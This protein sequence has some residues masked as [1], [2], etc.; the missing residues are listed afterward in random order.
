VSLRNLLIA[1]GLLICSTLIFEKFLQLPQVLWRLRVTDTRSSN[2]SKFSTGELSTKQGFIDSNGDWKIA[3]TFNFAEPFSEGLAAVSQEEAETRRGRDGLTSRHCYIDKTGK[4]LIKTDKWWSGLGKFSGGHARILDDSSASREINTRGQTIRKFDERI[5]LR[6]NSEIG[7]NLI[8]YTNQQRQ[9]WG[10]INPEGKVVVVAQFDAAQPIKDGIGVFSSGGHFVSRGCGGGIEGSSKGAVDSNGKIVLQPIFEDLDNL[11]KSAVFFKRGNKW[12]TMDLSGKIVLQPTF[13]SVNT[14]FDMADKEPYRIVVRYLQDVVDLC[15]DSLTPQKPKPVRVEP[16]EG[17]AIATKKSGVR[18]ISAEGNSAPSEFADG[19]PFS[20]GLAAVA[21]NANGQRRY[22]FID[23]TFAIKIPMIFDN[24]RS[25]H[26]GFAAVKQYEKW[27]F[28]DHDG[29]QIAGP[30]FDYISDF[31]EGTAHFRKAEKLGLIHSDGKTVYLQNINRVSEFSNGLA[32]A[33]YS[34]PILCA[35][36]SQSHKLITRES[37]E[38]D[39]KMFP[40]W[41]E[42]TFSGF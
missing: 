5:K 34:K 6:D 23:K 26:N 2:Q 4:I 13:D 21:R 33:E 31:S 12:G 19:L 35:I 16:S 37:T 9:K 3:P 11:S 17:Y 14:T 29:N 27:G 7:K 41:S 42:N 1:A 30:E 10:Y 40:G 18:F 39:M 36:E 38:E 24:A 15:R 22:G 8:P 32:V 20:E 28:I 25:F